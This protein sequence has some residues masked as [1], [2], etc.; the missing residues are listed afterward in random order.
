MKSLVLF[1]CFL[2]AV[3]GIQSTCSP[4]ARAVST[5]VSSPLSDSSL[6]MLTKEQLMGQFDPAVDSNFVRVEA[7]YTARAGML[8]R[9]EVYEAF[10]KMWQAARKE[11]IT[12][13]IISSTRNFEQQ[14][15]IWE[16]KW[17]RFAK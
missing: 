9:R 12:L 13:T 11:N 15:K 14:K 4:E 3:I 10:K 2:T 16:G 1:S 7:P 6:N 17:E 8:L 5:S